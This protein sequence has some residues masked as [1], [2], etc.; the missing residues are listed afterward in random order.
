MRSSHA[1][2]LSGTI[3]P[4]SLRN[5]KSESLGE[6]TQQVGVPASPTDLV[7]ANGQMTFTFQVPQITRLHDVPKQTTFSDQQ[8]RIAVFDNQWNFVWSGGYDPTRFVQAII[9]DPATGKGT[10][11]LSA[12]ALATIVN[13]RGAYWV[14]EAKSYSHY[15]SGGAP[16]Y[17][18]SKA[19]RV[20][21]PVLPAAGKKLPPP[22][23]IYSPRPWPGLA[24]W[25]TL[26]S[27]ISATVD[28]GDNSTDYTQYS[29]GNSGL[30]FTT[31]D[32]GVIVATVNG[33]HNRAG[34]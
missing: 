3:S 32:N 21:L 14:V 23:E 7:Q 25:T 31:G 19:A 28:W 8:I 18:W 27:R 17:Y 10:F 30:T 9:T 13:G 29:Q 4:D 5:K 15:S 34:W 26:K 1:A 2:F 16:V 12:D 33:Q 24:A 6:L 11:T 20:R 22:K